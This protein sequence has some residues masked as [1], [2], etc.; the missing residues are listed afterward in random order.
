MS[1]Q[2]QPNTPPFPIAVASPPGVGAITSGQA[3][4]SGTFGGG[5]VAFFTSSITWTVPDGVFSV[6]ARVFSGGGN[7]FAPGGLNTGGAGAGAFSMKTVA[8]QPGQQIVIT[9]GGAAQTS[10]F[11]AYCSCTGG[12]SAT[13]TT[14]AKAG[15]VA[16]GGD[17]N[18][19]GGDGGDSDGASSTAAG[20][21]VGNLFGVGGK[22][23]GAR[24]DCGWGATSGG[25]GT[26]NGVGGPGLAGDAPPSLDFLGCGRGGDGFEKV[27]G[28]T[29][30]GGSSG[31]NGGGGGA[32]SQTAGVAAGGSGGFPGGA[33]G[34]GDDN[35]G[36]G[37]PGCVIVEF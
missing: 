3:P 4:F 8:V 35:F 34:N 29:N 23:A 15:G 10:S 36:P 20:G 37:A 18:H 26:N 22:G 24:R 27:S 31:R 9:V 11:G 33:G 5:N 17:V 2:Y 7:G 12:T 13:N 16:T 30:G 25:G 14:G 21:G 1:F 19:N 28:L 32:G 6:R